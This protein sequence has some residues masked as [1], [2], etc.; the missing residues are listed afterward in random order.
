MSLRPFALLTALG[1]LSACAGEP[2]I[3]T[4]PAVSPVEAPPVA[5]PVAPLPEHLRELR[6]L[7]LGVPADTTVELA[8]LLV[9]GKDHPGR[10]LTSATLQGDGAPLAFR[11]NFNPEVFPQNGQVE[12]R[13]RVTQSGVLILRLPPIAIHTPTS[14]DLGERR[15]ERAP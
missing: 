11:L 1:L 3:P 15:L 7:L 5:A 14:Q 6:G 2:A 9:D 12:L 8:L 4:A 10:L 13:G